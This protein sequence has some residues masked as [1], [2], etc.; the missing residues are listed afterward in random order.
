MS[1]KQKSLTDSLAEAEKQKALIQD[2]LSKLDRVREAIQILKKELERMTE[3]EKT[4]E[5]IS[6]AEKQ[7]KENR[8]RQASIKEKMEAVKQ[9]VQSQQDELKELQLIKNSFSD[10]YD[11]IGKLKDK[12]SEAMQ[13]LEKLKELCD[14]R[15]EG[16]EVKQVFSKAN[17]DLKQATESLDEA[18][19]AYYSNIAVVLAGDLE[20]NEPCPV[21]GGTDHPK[22]SSRSS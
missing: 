10:S 5:A 21:C 17:K 3:V 11:R 14:L 9:A 12:K 2:E 22:K 20:Q 19:A 4:E 7:L 18:K 6:Q 16:A 1:E 13:R 15:K 8:L